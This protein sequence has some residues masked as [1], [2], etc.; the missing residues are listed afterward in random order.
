[1]FDSSAFTQH[2]GTKRR[3]EC[4]RVVV[5]AMWRRG[6]VSQN[7]Q[8]WATALAVTLAFGCASERSDERAMTRMDGSAGLSQ[9]HSSAVASD[10]SVG[11]EAGVPHAD[12]IPFRVVRL[13][14]GWMCDIGE[15]NCWRQLEVHEDLTF[16]AADSLGQE[17]FGLSA[18]QFQQI[19]EIVNRDSLKVALADT[20]GTQ[21]GSFFGDNIFLTVEW[22]NGKTLRASA[23]GCVE[24]EGH[25]YNELV[26]A[27]AELRVEFVE[28]VDRSAPDFDHDSIDTSNIR[29]LCRPCSGTC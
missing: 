6:A 16:V 7:G 17:S 11:R 5:D 14:H 22:T 13:E 20:A 29:G 21:C 4:E 12:P 1:M 24:T 26:Y 28:C 23:A 3:G 10:T 27:L 8:R 15:D 18:E 9:P 19:A 2:L 25:I